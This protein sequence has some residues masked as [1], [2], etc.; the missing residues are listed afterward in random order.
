MTQFF[1]IAIFHFH[2]TIFFAFCPCF[3]GYQCEYKRRTGRKLDGCMIAFKKSHFTL[4]SLHPVEF[5][6]QGIQILDRDN[7][8]LIVVL[9]PALESGLD[10]SIC[11][12]TTHL[13]YNPRRGDIKL[14]Q[15]ALLLA[16]ISRVAL[17]D[18]GTTCPVL[19]CGDFNSVPTS[20]LYT[21]ITDSKLE[22]A[23]I[24]IG[25]VRELSHVRTFIAVMLK[26]EL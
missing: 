21:F 16:E 26:Q 4:S 24:P 8:G 1:C 10:R 18:D 14:A 15:L 13:L 7:V 25:K 2:F 20:P 11:V 22:Y 5:F 19:L 3:S 12:V 6:R 17:Q 9:K 23:G